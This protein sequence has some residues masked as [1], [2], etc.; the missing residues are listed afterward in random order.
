M[1]TTKK[2]LNL[3]LPKDIELALT[4]LSKR[5]GVQTAT[6]ALRMIE[7]ALEIEEDEIWQRIALNRDQKDVEYISHDDVWV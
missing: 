1:P 5:D 4:S 6:K 7:L 2:R 3:S